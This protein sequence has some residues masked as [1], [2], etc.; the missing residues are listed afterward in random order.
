M[1]FYDDLDSIFDNDEEN[2]IENQQEDVDQNTD[3]NF[4][5]FSEEDILEDK[6]DSVTQH[7]VINKYLES[8]GFVDSKIKVIDENNEESE[9][10]FSELSE[11]EQLDILNSIGNTNNN[12]YSDQELEWVNQLR[13]NNLTMDSFLELYRQSIIDEINQQGSTVSY[14]IDS[15][16]DEE[17]Y[18]LDLKSRYDLSDEELQKEL[19]QELEDKDKFSK[20]INKIREEY[21]DLED[22]ERANQKAQFEAQQQQEYDGFVNQML[23]VA[24]NTSEYHG[25]ELEDSDKNETLSYLVELDATGTS[26]FY[27]DLNDPN[28]LF[29]AAWYLKH[30]KEAFKVV[31]EAYEA[32]IARLKNEK[33]KPR[34]IVRQ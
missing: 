10:L 2:I 29:E 14:D 32:E 13:A 24:Q 31:S 12:N 23:G 15:Y 16:S 8:K 6:E 27:R 17:L 1:E 21:K 9:I 11:E 3:D 22:Q 7:S 28:K 26:K 5:I 33:D 19:E 25:L 20:K 34:V 18:L 4:D 30:G